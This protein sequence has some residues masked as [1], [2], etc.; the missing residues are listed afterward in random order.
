MEAKTTPFESYNQVLEANGKIPFVAKLLAHIE[1][2]PNSTP[3]S[4]FWIGEAPRGG[5]LWVLNPAITIEVRWDKLDDTTYYAGLR[6]N[7]DQRYE[8]FPDDEVDNLNVPEFATVMM[9]RYE[10]AK[11]FEHHMGSAASALKWFPNYKGAEADERVM[12]HFGVTNE[13]M[14]SYW[15]GGKRAAMSLKT[16][17]CDFMAAC[18]VAD[19]I[20]EEMPRK[21]KE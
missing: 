14:V 13:C 20:E 5:L 6:A 16:T 2:T 3:P 18:I 4:Q 10:R 15:M 11:K 21:P 19:Y 17:T 12:V 7:D 9:T 8:F 1:K